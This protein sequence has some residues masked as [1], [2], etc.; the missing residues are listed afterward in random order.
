MALRLRE[1]VA[2]SA[3]SDALVQDASA[4]PTTP[5][6]KLENAVSKL[7]EIGPNVEYVSWRKILKMPEEE[8]LKAK[9]HRNTAKMFALLFVLPALFMPA[10]INAFKLRFIALLVAVLHFNKRAPAAEPNEDGSKPVVWS[11]YRNAILVVALGAF[12]G[13]AAGWCLP[14]IS[15]LFLPNQLTFIGVVVGSFLA[16]AYWKHSKPKAAFS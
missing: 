6:E 2:G 15:T 1:R 9:Q 3:L 4:G 14:L 5:K 13:V 12:T 8:M 10:L 11:Q 16:D 7:A